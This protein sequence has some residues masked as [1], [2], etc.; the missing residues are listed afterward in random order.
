M[1]NGIVFSGRGNTDS[2]SFTVCNVAF[3]VNGERDFRIDFLHFSDVSV[4]DCVSDRRGLPWHE[5]PGCPAKTKV[6]I[7]LCQSCL[8]SYV[9]LMSTIE[10]LLL[11]NCHTLVPLEP[12]TPN[13]TG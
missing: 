11:E 9:T 8:M 1:Q 10:F 12:Q 5:S 13:T 7:E 4:V 2:Y 6:P 3:S